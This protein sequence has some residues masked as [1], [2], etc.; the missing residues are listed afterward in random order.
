MLCANR[1]TAFTTVQRTLLAWERQVD[2]QQGLKIGLHL[3]KG[4]TGGDLSP[5]LQLLL[6][7]AVEEDTVGALASTLHRV[8]DWAAAPVAAVVAVVHGR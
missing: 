4:N 8:L 3:P 1:V 5:V 7:W 2:R 6:G